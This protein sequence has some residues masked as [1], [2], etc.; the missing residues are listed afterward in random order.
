MGTT[1]FY[2][3]VPDSVHP[4]KENRLLTVR[5]LMAAVVLPLLLVSTTACSHDDPA[6]AE[7]TSEIPADWK[8]HQGEG[9]AISAPESF[10]RNDTESSNGERMLVLERDSEI[11]DVPQR[12]AVLRDVDPA[13]DAAEQSQTLAAAQSV[14]VPEGT[15]VRKEVTVPEGESAY[16]IVW[17]Q[18]LP[19]AGGTTATVAYQQ[20]MHQVSED[21]ILNVVAFT[22]ADEFDA[23]GVAAIADTFRPGR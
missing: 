9:F 1:L 8:L 7:P 15:V 14:G 10:V 6:P 22:L 13:A 5:R 4:A 16:L 21:L 19:V 23:S 3:P 17:Q 2:T 12:V 11:L 20:L 18:E